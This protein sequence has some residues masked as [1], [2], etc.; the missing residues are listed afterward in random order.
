MR[1]FFVA[2]NGVFGEEPDMGRRH[3]D[4][5]HLRALNKNLSLGLQT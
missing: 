5:Q 3:V 4:D 1:S 2:A